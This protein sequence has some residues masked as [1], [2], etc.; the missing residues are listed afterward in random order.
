MPKIEALL[1]DVG[2]VVVEFDFERAFQAWAP[3][4]ALSVAEMRRRFSM[5][6][7]YQKHE[8]GEIAAPQYFAHLRET[9]ALHGSDA[10]IAQGGNA[11]FIGEIAASVNTIRAAAR[12][13]PCFAFTNSNPTH[14]ACWTSAY[15]GVVALFQRIF[16]SSDLGLRKPAKQAFEAVAAAANLAPASIVFFDDAIDNVHGAQA[17]GMHGV[18]V[19]QPEDLQRA[20]TELGVL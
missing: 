5:D 6:E 8:R 2:G 13:W 3:Q 18:H 19:Q 1:F 15:P 10:S 17:A 12:H 16:V 9:L 14:M 7:A 4:S 20:L 11:I